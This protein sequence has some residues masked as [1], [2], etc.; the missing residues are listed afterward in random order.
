[1]N[2]D[3][4]N[5]RNFL[6]MGS[7]GIAAAAA[8]K[9]G[10]NS[11]VEAAETKKPD[12][13]YRTLGRT[14]LKVSVVGFGA[15]RSSEPA[16][17]KAAFDRGVNWLDTAHNYMRGR[18]EKVCG[19]AL[20]GYRDKVYVTTKT[21]AR[22][23]DEIFS[24]AETS[25]QSLGTDHID[26]YLLHVVD[27]KREVMNQEVREAFAELRKQ[28]KVRFLGVSTHE[29]Q[30]EVLDAIAQDPDRFFD[31]AL[32]QYN[33][34]SPPPVKE[35]IAN[36]AKVGVGIIAM[37]TQAGG[38]KTKELGDISPHQAALK[39]VLQDTNVATTVPAMLNL[40]QLNEDTQVME[41][42][43]LSKV[44]KQI[45]SQYGKAI[46]SFHCSTCGGCKGTC[47]KGVRIPDVNRCL[48][49]AEGYGDMELA[50][51]AYSTLPREL[52]ASA[53]TDCTTCVAKCVNGIDIASRMRDARA[54]FA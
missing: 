46:A 37:K 48:M 31:A 40:D 27:S 10:Q 17:M 2:P 47:P 28:G 9:P 18:N 32:V 1:M 24:E 53:C 39:W 34:K 11:I 12:I 7:L 14:G 49:Y 16:V 44:D 21:G 23:K 35:A 26:L 41:L 52:T 38:Y 25:L 3:L 13:V 5:R 19:E 50:L 33:F 8:G 4:F 42:L 54:M 29:N 20:K 15:M 45:L 22:S 6:K 30:P 36:A 51:E 43:K